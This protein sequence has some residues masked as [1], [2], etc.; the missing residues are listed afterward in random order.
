MRFT[1]LGHVE[2]DVSAADGELTISV[3]DTGP[4][5]KPGDQVRIFQEF[6]Q[7]DDSST[8]QKGGTGLGLSIC[9]RLVSMHGG[10]IDLHSVVG[11]GS[12]LPMVLP[13]RVME[14]R[15]PP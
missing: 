7:V 14:Q 15:E 9:R 4:G 10:R 12:T 8:R 13:L 1:D 6:Q 11:V 5:I 2:V 3:Q